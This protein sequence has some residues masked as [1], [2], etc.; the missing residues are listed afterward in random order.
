MGHGY[1]TIIAYG[2]VLT[3]AEEAKYFGIRKEYVRNLAGMAHEILA[4]YEIGIAIEQP[5]EVEEIFIYQLTAS[6]EGDG[7]TGGHGIVR[8]QLQALLALQPDG[9][10]QSLHA[11]REYLRDQANIASFIREIDLSRAEGDLTE[12]QGIALF[13]RQLSTPEDLDLR[14]EVT[15][16]S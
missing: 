3:L 1:Y 8:Q 15:Q 14:P 6:I 16:Y 12:A 10:L 4:F 13:Q 7:R 2:V 11:V 9:F 5:Q